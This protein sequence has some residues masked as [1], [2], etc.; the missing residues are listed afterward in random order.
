MTSHLLMGQHQGNSTKAV[1]GDLVFRSGE[2]LNGRRGIFF[3]CDRWWPPGRVPTWSFRPH[4]GL[5]LFAVWMVLLLAGAVASEPE[6]ASKDAVV[7]VSV[8]TLPTRLDGISA[9]CDWGLNDTCQL[10]VQL[11]N[12]SENVWKSVTADGGCTCLKIEI[13]DIPSGGVTPGDLLLA[14]LVYSRP[15]E[16]GISP[17]S[18][19]F[20]IND[21]TAVLPI[22]VS[23]HAPV[24]LR[25]IEHVEP[26][27]WQIHGACE[28]GWAIDLIKLVDDDIELLSQHTEGRSFQIL[29]KSSLKI[30]RF[31]RL[32]CSV[33]SLD[34]S[35]S[36]EQVL[37][38][39]L[40][41]DQPRSIPN[42]LICHVGAGGILTG[43]TRL[44]FPRARHTRRPNLKRGFLVDADGRK[45]PLSVSQKNLGKT[46]LRVHFRS[47]VPVSSGDL[48]ERST[49]RFLFD[50]GSRLDCRFLISEE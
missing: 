15:S 2:C 20:S 27:K 30:D 18:L 1:A 9:N 47:D 17:R 29:L 19:R 34:A 37:K 35:K 49:I 44:L 45:V 10:T 24:A 12:D 48:C 39:Q 23:W 16:P 40:S 42:R 6:L 11:R 26:D 50:D 13:N 7:R 8:G 5:S 43:D 38:F 22:V 36:L 14:R 28:E 46:A 4:S 32:L 3:H 31:S 25:R 21:S 41:N 33:T